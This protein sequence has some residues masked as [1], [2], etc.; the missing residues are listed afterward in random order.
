MGGTSKSEQTSTS[1]TNPW[2]PAQPAI[3]GILGQLEPLIQGSGLSPTSTNAINQLQTNAQQGNPYANQISSLTGGILGNIGQNVATQPGAVQGALD[4]YRS[5]LSPYASGQNIGANSGLNNY[6]QT[7]GNDVQNR[8]NSMFAGAGRDMSGANLQTL[9]RG[10]AEGT[11]PV[12]A[13]QYNQDV[14]NQLG[15]AGSL[16]GAANQTAGLLTGLNQQNLSN[17][18]GAADLGNTALAA[19]NYG[20]T[21]MLNLEQLRQSIPAQN[22]GLLAQIGIPIAGLGGTASG[23][24]SGTNQM[25]GA[26]QFALIANGI[27]SMMPKTPI[28]FG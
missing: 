6:L 24:Q 20:P 10:I 1:A 13:N 28:K 2:D 19:Q 23:T 14:Q 7:I 25:S 26:Q 11:A 27:G 12:I 21:Q 5:Q 17:V 22:L 8:V 3:K 9:S 4:T 18:Q 16:Y 15:A